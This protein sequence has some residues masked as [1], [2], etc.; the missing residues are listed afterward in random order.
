L[1]V[2]ENINGD[3][4]EFSNEDNVM[5]YSNIGCYINQERLPQTAIDLII[6]CFN[7][8][9]FEYH[10]YYTGSDD[11]EDFS[12]FVTIEPCLNISLK[13][14]NVKRGQF[15]LIGLF[16]E[17]NI[18]KKSSSDATKYVLKEFAK[19]HLNNRETWESYSYSYF[20]DIDENHELVQFIDGDVN[21]AWDTKGNFSITPNITNNILNN[22]FCIINRNIYENSVTGNLNMLKC[23]NLCNQYGLI[24]PNVNVEYPNSKITAYFSRVKHTSISG[25]PSTSIGT[26]GMIVGHGKTIGGFGLIDNG[27]PTGIP[28]LI[29]S[30]PDGDKQISKHVSLKALMDAHPDILKYGV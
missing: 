7:N 4:M 11:H 16:T 5:R 20:C 24:S 12:I 22:S 27:G 14:S 17:D 15:Q 29:Y 23:I 9:G 30:Y 13:D 8:K 19:S 18:L 2:G 26:H 10:K 6:S 25:Q 1:K 3:Y 28:S 21:W